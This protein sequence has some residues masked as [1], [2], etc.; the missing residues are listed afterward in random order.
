M[1]SNK[2]LDV[3]FTKLDLNGD[4]KISRDEYEVELKRLNLPTS[5]LDFTDTVSLEYDKM[6]DYSCDPSPQGVFLFPK[7]QQIHH[8][9]LSSINQDQPDSK[10]SSLFLVFTG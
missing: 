8:T 9:L 3:R 1:K 5:M 10:G 6:T 4:G 2:D 7:I